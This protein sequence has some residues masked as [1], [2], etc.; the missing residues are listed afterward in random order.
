[1]Y[2]LAQFSRNRSRAP[3][4]L[5]AP[6]FLG[7]AAAW[8]NDEDPD[9][10]LC[11]E[12]GLAGRDVAWDEVGGPS[13]LLQPSTPVQSYLSLD[14]PW[15]EYTGGWLALPWERK[16]SCICPRPTPHPPDRPPLPAWSLGTFS[17]RPGGAW[18]RPI[19]SRQPVTQEEAALAPRP[20]NANSSF[21]NQ[22]GL[23]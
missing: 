12:A 1:M 16:I 19:P 10:D 7:W 14:L 6:A 23:T 20:L 15:A 21:R 9:P 17:P 2:T 4:E 5:V 22:A 13:C 8:G 3:S 11:M 18:A